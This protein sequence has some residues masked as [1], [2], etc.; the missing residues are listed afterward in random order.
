M[1]SS[2]DAVFGDYGFSSTAGDVNDG[3]IIALAI[4]GC[5]DIYEILKPLK[6]LMIGHVALS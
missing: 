1:S 2:E 3:L 5:G 4:V 6:V